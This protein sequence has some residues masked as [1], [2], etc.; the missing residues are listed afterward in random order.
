M[1]PPGNPP[2]IEGQG[3]HRAVLRTLAQSLIKIEDLPLALD[4]ALGELDAQLG[5]GPSRV[6]AL[7]RGGVLRLVASH[8]VPPETLAQ[9]SAVNLGQGFSGL[10]AQRRRMVVMPLD[11]L[12]D[13]ER[14]RTLAGLGVKAV[15][16][17]PLILHGDLVGAL[18]VATRQ[19]VGFTPDEQGFLDV[20]AGLLAAA[21]AAWLRCQRLDALTDELNQVRGSIDLKVAEQVGEIREELLNLTQA[22]RRLRQTWN[23]VMQAERS[24]AVARF[25]SALAHELRNPLMVIGGFA[26]RL[27]GTIER[28]DPRSNYVKVIVHEV[29]AL[30]QLLG[31]FF[32]LNRERDLDYSEVDPGQVMQEA[33]TRAVA[34]A[35]QPQE[36]PVWSLG[37]D[38]PPAVTDRDLLV[39]ALANLVQNAIEATHA[40]GRVHLGVGQD[41]G[42]HLVF[43]VGDE[44]PGISPPERSRIFDPLYTTKEYG[45]GLGLPVCRDVVLLLGGELMVGDRPG[46]GALFTVR[47]PT[48][49]PESRPRHSLQT[50]EERGSE[51]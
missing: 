33:W 27:A 21:V 11:G 20:L 50:E 5:L 3:R 1:N 17:L 31:Q 43:S 7:R 34:A 8:G 13:P 46:G 2:A 49:P 42:G 9:V 18:N 22:N 30:E 44:G 39:R 48:R 36:E 16:A 24:A 15:C 25:T 28:Q 12:D 37:R 10:A 38:L 14:R 29:Q 41:N 4:L 45:V 40:G 35:G 32:K 47:L 26:K 23:L 6:Y 51:A 19:R